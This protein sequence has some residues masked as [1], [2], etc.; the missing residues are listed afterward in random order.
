MAYVGTLARER[1]FRPFET[2][3]PRSTPDYYA[4]VKKPMDMA[5]V[6]SELCLLCCLAVVQAYVSL[7]SALD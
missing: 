7:C 2:P 4:L 3:V 6:K 5:T 1:D